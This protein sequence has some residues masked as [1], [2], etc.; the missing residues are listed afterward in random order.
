MIGNMP[1]SRHLAPPSSPPLPGAP[2][3][4]PFLRGTGP[5]YIARHIQHHTYLWTMSGH[6]FWVYPIAVTNER[7]IA[8]AW[9][10]EQWQLVQ[11]ELA[12][13]DSIY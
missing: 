6:S 13:I 1:H 8:Y 11:M 5:E 3:Y 4:C 7:L 2:Q 10:N 12:A 9:N